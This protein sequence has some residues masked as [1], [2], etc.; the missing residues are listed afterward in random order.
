M[1]LA[2]RQLALRLGSGVIVGEL[3]GVGLAAAV[4]GSVGEGAGELGV[5]E[6]GAGGTTSGLTAGGVAGDG[7]EGVAGAELAGET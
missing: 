1:H 7:G 4:G 2:L 5:G 3:D 6:A